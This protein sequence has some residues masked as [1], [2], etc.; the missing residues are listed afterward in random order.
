MK[1][2]TA[3]KDYQFYLKIEKGLAKNSI[4][5]YSRDVKKL[6]GYLELNDMPIS[7]ISIEKKEIQEFIYT[8]AKSINP[9]SK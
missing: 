8:A 3:L 9:R 5:S 4:E 7:P 1:W 2:N 6:I